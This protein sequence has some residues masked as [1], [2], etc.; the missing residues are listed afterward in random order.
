[1][2][3]LCTY[4]RAM[5]ICAHLPKTN[6]NKIVDISFICKGLKLEITKVSFNK[7]M[8][9]QTVIHPSYGI[10]FSNEKDWTIDTYNNLL[11]SQGIMLSEKIQSRKVTYFM[12][13]LVVAR[14]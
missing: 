8:S 10:L 2:A 14:S 5:K 7:G 1:M 12:F 13:P 6:L 3:F 9:K 11:C 4:P